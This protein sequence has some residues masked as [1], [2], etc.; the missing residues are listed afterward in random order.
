MKACCRNRSSGA[1]SHYAGDTVGIDGEAP[2]TDGLPA[3]LLEAIS[4]SIVQ[5]WLPVS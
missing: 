4:D 1:A 3:D 5:G 2:G